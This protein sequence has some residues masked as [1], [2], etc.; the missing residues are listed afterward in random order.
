LHHYG[1]WPRLHN[2]DFTL[3]SD[4]GIGLDWPFKYNELAPF[5]DRIQDEI[6]V[7][8]DHKLE[9]W[10]P[11]GKDYP[12]P[13]VPTLTQGQ[14]I[15]KGFEKLGLHTSPIPL[16]I[17]TQPWKGRSPCIYDGWCDAGCPIGALGNALVH[18]LPRAMTASD[19]S[20]HG[21]NAKIIHHA[22]VAK[23]LTNDAGDKAVGVTYFNQAGEEKTLSAKAIVLAAFTVQN[24]RILL[25][26]ATAAHPN[27]IANEHDLVGRYLMT[28]PSK[29][30]GGIF[31][32]PTTP[33]LGATA[34]QLICQEDYDN[35]VKK[36][37]AFG[38]Y[39]WL[40]ANAVKPNDLLGIANSRPDIYGDKLKPFMQAAAKHYGTMA[41]VTE[42]IANFDNRVC[43]SEDKDQFGLPLAKTIHNT[44]KE[45][46]ALLDQAIEQ[47]LNVFKAA[48]ATEAW[49]G[50][51]YG[52]HLMGGTIMGTKPE[53]S[54][55]NQYGQAH[56][57]N[58]LFISGPGLFPS[59][60]AVNPTFTVHALALRSA[61][62]LINNWASVTR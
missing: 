34:G 12:M 49:A 61:E 52:M 47:G 58:N 28:H 25:N 46:E 14:V 8:G 60:G 16:A 24:P 18:Y 42:G 37:E 50:Q 6:G 9:K 31:K 13:A 36:G 20:E 3:N 48:G 29:N 54:V 51:A 27:G 53:N 35:K 26:S 56:G 19:L 30:I 2:G 1:V 62:Y 57:V 11:K 38:S 40:I 4:H 59:G 10:R 7:S 15:K 32:D 45:S 22:T 17:N 39:Q 41:C 44:S 33:H 21:H 55:T 43:L 5:Y 23:V